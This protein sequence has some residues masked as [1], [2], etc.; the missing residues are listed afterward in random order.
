MLWLLI[1]KKTKNHFHWGILHRRLIKD[2]KLMPLQ[3]Q[4]KLAYNGAK[5]LMTWLN[6]RHGPCTLLGSP[7]ACVLSVRLGSWNHHVSYVSHPLR[8]CPVCAD[9]GK[10][11]QADDAWLDIIVWLGYGKN[12]CRFRSNITHLCVCPTLP[13]L[14]LYTV[15][16]G[17]ML[18]CQTLNT[19]IQVTKE[20]YCR[21]IEMW[22]LLLQTLR[23][24]VL[25]VT[26]VVPRIAYFGSVGVWISS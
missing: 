1:F 26:E 8:F 2:G 23:W 10:C 18:I 21:T 5:V 14:H 16:N 6:W 24:L 12:A 11:L 20:Y 19:H 7:L 9:K 25:S 15:V 22:K 17:C 4:N 3:H 13:L